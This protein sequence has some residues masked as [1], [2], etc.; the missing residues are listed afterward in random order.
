MSAMPIGLF[1]LENL[2]MTGARFA[3]FDLR[4]EAKPVTPHIDRLLMK[5][6][7]V[8]VNEAEARLG[9]IV[10][11]KSA[12]V[13]L[14]C[15]NGKTSRDLAHRLESAGYANVYVVSGGVEGL[16]SEL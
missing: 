16:L 3:F 2:S 15:E 13:V 14:L 10:P 4:V 8:R 5:A 12:P 9:K 1:Q 11:D 7:H 6:E